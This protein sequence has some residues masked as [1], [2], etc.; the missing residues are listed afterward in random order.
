MISRIL[1]SLAAL[2]LVGFA[3][4]V[5]IGLW[6]RHS[7]ETAALGFSGVYERYLASQAGVFR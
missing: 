3:D 7:Q 6:D 5:L 1:L 4:L 2:A